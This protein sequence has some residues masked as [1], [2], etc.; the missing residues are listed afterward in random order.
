MPLQQD[1]SSYGIISKVKVVVG[2]WILMMPYEVNYLRYFEVNH[3]DYDPEKLTIEMGKS[4]SS[5]KVAIVNGNYREF[6]CYEK[7]EKQPMVRY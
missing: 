4:C 6:G 3:S 5:N 7:V 2:F 1:R